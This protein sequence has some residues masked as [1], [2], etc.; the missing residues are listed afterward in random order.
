MKIN[1]LSI[2]GIKKD[3]YPVIKTKIQEINEIKKNGFP[4]DGL[5][6][7]SIY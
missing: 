6:L 7:I 2:F 3:N 4:A 1:I 5:V